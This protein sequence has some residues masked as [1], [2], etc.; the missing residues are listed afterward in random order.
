MRKGHSQ[1]QQIQQ[2]PEHSPTKEFIEELGRS[3]L[4]VSKDGFK[5]TGLMSWVVLAGVIILVYLILKKRG[6]IK[7]QSSRL[8]KHVTTKINTRRS[9]KK[10][11]KRR[12]KNV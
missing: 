2:H 5:V 7:Q 6:Y 11:R 3:N 12:T 4:E 9:K 10:T 8:K 1:Q